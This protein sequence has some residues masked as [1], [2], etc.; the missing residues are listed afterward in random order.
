MD[1]V[2]ELA[3]AQAQE[4]QVSEHAAILLYYLVLLDCYGVL[5]RSSTLSKF[6]FSLACCCQACLHLAALH[7]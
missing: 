7:T 2:Q 6:R 5:Q 4:P 1:L 3:L